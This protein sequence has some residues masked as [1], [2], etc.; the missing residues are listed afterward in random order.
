MEMPTSIKRLEPD[1]VVWEIVMLLTPDLPLET[2]STAGAAA[3]LV[4]VGVGVGVLVAVG[5]GVFVGVGVAVAVAVGV[6]VEVGVGVAEQSLG[7]EAASALISPGLN[8]R[9]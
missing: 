4:A 5:V 7:G 9:L 6:G 3:A 2:V 1:E 8:T